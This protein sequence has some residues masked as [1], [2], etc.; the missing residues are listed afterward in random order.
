VIDT[1]SYHKDWYNVFFCEKYEHVYKRL[2]SNYEE[3]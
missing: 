3:I 2:G 1:I